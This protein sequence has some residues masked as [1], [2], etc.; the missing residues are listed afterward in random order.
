MTLSQLRHYGYMLDD[1]LLEGWLQIARRPPRRGQRQAAAAVHLLPA[2]RS[3]DQRLRHPRRLRRRQRRP[4][5]GGRPRGRSRRR[6]LAR[7]RARH[8]VA[9][10]ARGGT[11]ADGQHPD[12]AGDARRDR[13]R[14]VGRRQFQRRRRA[15]PRCVSAQGLMAQ[16]QIDY[17]R[18]NE[19]EADRIGIQTLARSGYDPEAMADFF[20]QA[21]GAWSRS[22]HGGERERTPDYL[23]THPVTTTRISEARERAE[24]LAAAPSRLRSPAPASATTRCCRRPAD[25][26]QRWQAATAASSTGRASACA[27]SAPTPRPPRSASTS[28][29]A[30]Q[31]GK[32]DDAQRYG[33]ALAR[34]RDGQ[35][36][37]AAAD[38]ADAAAGAS[39]DTAGSAL[40][41]GE[42]E[43]RSRQGRG[44]RCALRS[45]AARMPRQPRGGADLCRHARRTQHAGG[46]QA[47]AGGAAAAAG[48]RP[49][50]IRCSSRPSPA[51][52][53][54]PA[55]RSA[56]ARPMPRPPTSTAAR[57]RRWSSSTP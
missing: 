33:L 57:N 41:L 36:A 2:A 32:L 52:A 34:L 9:C 38:L 18:S 6:A 30:R 3:P 46:R 10:A 35:A 31:A 49:A 29:C 53:R 55:T 19:S 15:W 24:Q 5:A 20:E 4:G 37:A 48:A 44:R 26:R 21:A 28:A 27:C 42:A 14:A 12:P 51:P 13:G 47:R 22:N 11:R 40:A 17:T 25:R 23:Q 7:N 56:P 8:P 39:G 50:T 43:A 1:P 54:S 45:T 16:R